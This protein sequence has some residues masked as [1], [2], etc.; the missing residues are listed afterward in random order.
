MPN[1]GAVR[2]PRASQDLMDEAMYVEALVMSSGKLVLLDKLLP[3][4][5]EQ[6]HRVLVFSQFTMLLDL[7]EDYVR[8][9]D[10]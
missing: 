6:G 4:L 5:R 7:I 9:R 10:Y 1:S 2:L 3:R 8:L